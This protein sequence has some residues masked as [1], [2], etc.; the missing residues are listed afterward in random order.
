MRQSGNLIMPHTVTV[1]NI[2]SN[3]NVSVSEEQQHSNFLRYIKQKFKTLNECEHNI[4]LMMDEIHLKPFYDFNGG[5]IVGSAYDSE[6]AA[7]SAYTF[8]IRS[9]LSSYKDVAHILPIKSFS[10][11]KLFEILRDVIVG[12]EKIGFKVIC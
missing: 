11:E 5:N 2:R 12:L 8:R 6:F 4:I 10:A 7:S 1:R 9:L 3:L